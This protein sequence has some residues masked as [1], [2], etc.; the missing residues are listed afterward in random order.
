MADPYDR[1]QHAALLLATIGSAEAHR[2][3]AAEEMGIPEIFILDAPG[4]QTYRIYGRKTFTLRPQ[5]FFH[6]WTDFGFEARIPAHI[7]PRHWWYTA[8]SHSTVTE[9]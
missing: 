6:N 1:R 2:S 3:R 5:R 7:I 4:F 8:A 9:G